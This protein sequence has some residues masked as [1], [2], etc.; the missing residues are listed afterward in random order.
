MFD[1]AR[2]RGS[3]D[4]PLY[5]PIIMVKKA[6][7]LRKERNDDKYYAPLE[8]KN[9]EGLALVLEKVL[10]RPFKILFQEPM[11]MAI[12]LY[13]SVS[14]DFFCTRELSDGNYLLK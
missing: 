8:Q 14:N 12:T 11:L 10:A 13:M 3:A 5:S 9:N 7:K 2:M 1:D 6:K 4:N